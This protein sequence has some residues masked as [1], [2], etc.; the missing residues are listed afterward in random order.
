MPMKI[1]GCDIFDNCAQCP[2]PFCPVWEVEEE[3]EE[4][5]DQEVGL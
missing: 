1:D 3:E 5:E 4:Q 2:I